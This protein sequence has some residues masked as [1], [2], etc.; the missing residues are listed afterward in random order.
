MTIPPIA[1]SR[2]LGQASE[3][4]AELKALI[5]QHKKIWKGK[6]LSPRADDVCWVFEKTSHAL[7]ASLGHALYEVDRQLCEGTGGE[8]N[9]DACY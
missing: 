7:D 5:L 3:P 9:D 6:Q 4:G 1:R 8:W 2:S